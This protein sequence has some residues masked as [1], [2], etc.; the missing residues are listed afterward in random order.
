E[1]EVHPKE[2]LYYTIKV[3]AAVF[4]YGILYLFISKV[5][6]GS[7]DVIAFI[8]LTIYA[9]LIILYFFFRKGV[10]T[11]YLKGNA[12]KISE[13]QFPE[14]NQIVEEQSSLLALDYIPDVYFM[15][16]GGILNAFAMRFLGDNY[17][18]LYSDLV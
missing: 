5:F 18:V 11:G 15:Q 1:Y 4:G 8:P 13:K 14:I 7:R 16:S 3:V 9:V 2:N 6:F 10:L 12:I 17:V